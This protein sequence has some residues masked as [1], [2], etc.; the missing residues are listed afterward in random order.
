MRSS[1]GWRF[2]ENASNWRLA[3][4]LDECQR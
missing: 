3:V 1:S 4:S 2:I